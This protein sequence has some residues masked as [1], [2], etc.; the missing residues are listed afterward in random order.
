M[1]D[2]AT[3]QNSGPEPGSIEHMEAVL[4]RVGGES[5]AEGDAPTAAAA[6]QG[7]SPDRGEP[8]TADAAVEDGHEPDGDAEL[9]SAAADEGGAEQDG[10]DKKPGRWQKMKQRAQEAEQRAEAFAKNFDELAQV[11]ETA[12]DENDMLRAEVQRLQSLL[13][14]QYAHEEDPHEAEL[15]QYRLKEEAAKRAAERQAQEAERQQKLAQA[16]A[17]QELKAKIDDAA[18]KYRLDPEEFLQSYAVLHRRFPD[19]VDAARHVARTMGVAEQAALNGSAPKPSNPAKG[20]RAMTHGE[21]GSA[22]HIE[23]ILRK[24][25]Q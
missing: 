2:T 16:R 25:M 1:S 22:A 15:R 14:E 19:P 13:T 8:A 7:D 5:Q 21:R 10:A 12:Q 24:H 11:A 20:E 23:S 4:A 18:S 9:E 17:A 3:E 6:P